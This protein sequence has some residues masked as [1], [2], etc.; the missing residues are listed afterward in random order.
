MNEKIIFLGKSSYALGI[1]SD[2]LKLNYGNQICGLLSNISDDENDSLN[3]PYIIEG[4]A[5]K[6]HILDDFT[7]IQQKSLIIASIG[8][9]RKKI[10][11]FYKDKISYS[12]N[13]FPTLIHPSSVIG[14]NVQ[15]GMGFH[16]SPLSV[17]APFCTIKN[18]VVVNRNTSIGHHTILHDFVTVNPGVNIA[19]ICEVGE[20]SII[21][22]G[23]T[24]IDKITIGKN[25][26]IGAGSVVTKNIPDHVVAYG[27]PCKVI[28]DN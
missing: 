16:L 9:S 12:K 28:R 2:M 20:S 5:I 8:K 15:F 7:D 11:D 17:I 10:Y 1:I 4:I 6:E 22:A 18:F 19:G 3:H 21:G 13:S 23:T 24:I 25:S 27:N 14:S 26:I